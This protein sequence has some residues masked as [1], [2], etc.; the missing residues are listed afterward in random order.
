M[1]SYEDAIYE[2][3]A[4]PVTAYVVITSYIDEDGKTNIYADTPSDQDLHTSLGLVKFAEIY[5]NNRILSTLRYNS[6]ED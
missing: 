2:Q 1:P 5:M 6:K 4:G 3:V